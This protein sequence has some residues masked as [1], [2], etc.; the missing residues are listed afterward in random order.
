MSADPQ[1]PGTEGVDERDRGAALILALVM[2]ILGAT[3]VLPTLSYTMAV[4]R[5]SRVTM[6]RT[7]GDE[8]VKGGLRTALADPGKLYIECQGGSRTTVHPIATGISGVSTSCTWLGQAYAKDSTE[9]P[10]SVATVQA[11][12]TVPSDATPPNS[13]YTNSG[14]SNTHAWV[15]DTSP[16]STGSKIFAPNLPAHALSHPSPTGYPMPAPFPAC[17]VFFPGTYLNPITI[18][19]ATPTFFTSGI[20]Y[21]ESTV[22]ISGSAKVVVGDGATEGCTTDQEAA[23]NAVNAPVNHNITGVGATF[24]FGAA[25]RLVIN[26]STPGTGVSV[27]FNN[28]Y[29]GPTDVSTSSSAGVSIM[30]VNGVLAS[31]DIVDLDLP[32]QLFVPGSL[33]GGTTPAPATSPNYNP[34]TLVSSADPLTPSLPVVDIGLSTATPVTVLIPGYVATPQGTV[35]VNTLPTGVAGKDIEIEGGVLTAQAIISTQRPSTF[36]FGSINAVVQKT[37]KLVTTTTTS[38]SVS[39]AIV[40]VNSIGTYYVNSWEVQPS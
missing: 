35:N 20:Y 21:F 26:D 11:G 4:T 14:N 32:G 5:Q 34:S 31:P 28:R 24:V 27:K 37:F 40:Q 18:T 25:G 30:T 10:Y 7:T 3:V 2:I 19:S 39:T 33:V 6:T 16:T 13:W 17:N 15:A 22:T 12:S 23:F 9:I 1:L 8:E 38:R 29:V 36:V